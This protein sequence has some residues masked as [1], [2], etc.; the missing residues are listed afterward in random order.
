MTVRVAS[1]AALGFVFF[2]SSCGGDL[3]SSDLSATVPVGRGLNPDRCGSGRI[4]DLSTERCVDRQDPASIVSGPRPAPGTATYHPV[5]T[6]RL[7]GPYAFSGAYGSAVRIGIEDDSVDFT[8]PRFHGRVELEGAAFSY[9]RPLANQLVQ[10]AFASCTPD[11]PCRIFLVD[12][13]GDRARLEDLA[14]TVLEYAGLPGGNDRWFLHDAHEEGFGWSELPGAGQYEHGTLV[15]EVAAGYRFH[16][17]PF[18]DPVIVPMA[19]NFDE[20]REIG[21]YFS[22]LV[23]RSGQDP[24]RVDEL[25][26]EYAQGL[27]GQHEAADIINASYG[28]PAD[29]FSLWGRNASRIWEEDYR[30]LRDPD[31]DGNPDD[32]TRTWKEYVQSRTPPADRTLRVWAAGNHEPGSGVAPSVT[33][34]EPYGE[35]PNVLAGDGHRNLDALGPFH[36]PELRGQHLAVTALGTDEERLAPYA[37][38]CGELPED[39]DDSAVSR[40]GRHFCLAAPGTVTEGVEGTSFAA[41]FV[42]GVLAR[43][44]ARFEGVTPRELVRKLMDTADDYDDGEGFDGDIYVGHVVREEGEDEAVVVVGGGVEIDL[45]LSDLGGYVVVQRGCNSSLVSTGVAQDLCVVWG[46]GNGTL[47]EAAEKAQERFRYLYGAGRVDVDAEDGAFAPMSPPVVSASGGRPAPV[48]STR[49]RAPAAWGG[50]GDRLSG[51]SLVA[52]DSMEFP[53]RYRLRDLVADGAGGSSPI[54]EFLPERPGA[55]GCDPLRPFAPGL[56]CTPWASEA[57]VQTLLAPDGIGAAYRFGEGVVISGFTRAEGRLDAA[58]SGAFSFDGGSSLAAVRLDRSWLPAA[59]GAWRVDGTLTIAADLPSGIGGGGE[60]SIFEAGPALLSDWSVG[61]TRAAGEGRTRLALSQPARAEAGHGRFTV[62]SG[63]REDRTRL[64][65]TH[66][67][68]LVP[69]HRELTLRLS[70]QHPLLGGDLMVSAHR[71]E[72]PGHRPDRPEHGAGFAWRT[73]W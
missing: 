10:D 30:L 18:P 15:A 61:V 68:S 1:S 46:R 50:V 20:Q 53:F 65:E 57:A 5:S 29:L 24:V 2:L 31:R 64:Y 47:R 55:R 12:S 41:P 54:P 4:W 28:A 17:F 71:T 62:P 16:P 35:F 56:V 32:A 49:L 36:F 39:W 51:L 6:T 43:M 21:H 33:L 11:N 42:S 59:S 25:D 38:P 34:A 69:S 3:T 58:G 63:R 9:W 67:V 13:D 40:F 26:R 19:R 14:R 48:A 60:P 44:K 27:A 70:H 23:A 45:G 72:N 37:D 8:D 66:P 22:D 52:F 7:A 73:K